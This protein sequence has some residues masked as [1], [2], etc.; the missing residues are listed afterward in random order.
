MKEPSLP[1][2]LSCQIERKLDP[3]KR[4]SPLGG[5]GVGHSIKLEPVLKLPEFGLKLMAETLQLRKGLA[6][7]ARPIVICQPRHIRYNW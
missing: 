2:S 7:I 6:N 1:I 3:Q 5:E 4:K